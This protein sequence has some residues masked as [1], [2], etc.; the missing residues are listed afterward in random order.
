MHLHFK[1]ADFGTGIV[2]F[3][4]DNNEIPYSGSTPFVPGNDYVSNKFIGPWEQPQQYRL[5]VPQNGQRGAYFT[6]T[7]T[8]NEAF[9][10]WALNG[11]S[12]VYE[13]TSERTNTVR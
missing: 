10:Y 12:V 2:S 5:L 4:V 7:L 1:Q 11:F 8:T 6:F 3:Q 13:N 9:A